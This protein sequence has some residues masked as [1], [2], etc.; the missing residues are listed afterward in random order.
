MKIK[1]YRNPIII[2]IIILILLTIV[3]IFSLGPGTGPSNNKY[4]LIPFLE[5]FGSEGTMVV[6]NYLFI[7]LAAFGGIFFGY[8]L[9]PLF[10]YVHR[11]I[12]GR[13][14]VYGMLEQRQSEK[15]RA[16]FKAF[17]PALLAMN[18]GF[19]LSLNPMILDIIY[20]SWFIPEAENNQLLTMFI[21]LPITIGIGLALFSPIWFLCDAGIVYFPKETIKNKD[22]LNEIRSVGGW[23]IGFLKGYAGISILFFLYELAFNLFMVVPV[24]QGGLVIGIYFALPIFIPLLS[25]PAVILFDITFRKRKKFMQKIAE[26]LKI[27]D[28]LEISVEKI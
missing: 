21:L 11:L 14:M 18:F 26:R 3:L 12:F 23:Y 2:S 1:K 19:F 24:G 20:N 15:F 16:Y 22:Q 27:I 8:I 17:F 28:Y 10:L 9:G 13:K 7:I 25:L 5:S 6:L 4:K